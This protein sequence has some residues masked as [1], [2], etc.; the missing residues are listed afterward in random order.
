MTDLCQERKSNK[1]RDYLTM[2][3]PLGVTHLMLFT[4][5]AT[6][7]NTNLRIA[8]TPKGPTLTFRVESYSLSKDVKKP[9]KHV[10]DDPKT[11]LNPPLVCISRS[12]AAMLP[13]S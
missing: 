10:K 7:G 9:M 4:R 2:A 6:T 5:S 8:L 13:D 11:Y 3:G 12:K 1:L